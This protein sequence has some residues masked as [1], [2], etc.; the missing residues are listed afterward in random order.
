M[1]EICLEPRIGI[2]L[3]AQRGQ[4]VGGLNYFGIVLLL[5]VGDRVLNVDKIQQRGI[6][7]L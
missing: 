7:I 6:R 1:G 4:L 2:D 3:V 5:A